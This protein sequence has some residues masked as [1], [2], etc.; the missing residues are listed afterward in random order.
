MIQHGLDSAKKNKQ[1]RHELYTLLQ[2]G[3]NK[4]GDS[5]RSHLNQTL[6]VCTDNLSERVGLYY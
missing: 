2:E 5:N 6:W 4:N 1:L 3:Q